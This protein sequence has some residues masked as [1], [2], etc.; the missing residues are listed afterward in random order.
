METPKDNE[1]YLRVSKQDNR[2]LIHDEKA[3]LAVAV[4]AVEAILLVDNRKDNG[5]SDIVIAC[6]SGEKYLL[7]TYKVGQELNSAWDELVEEIEFGD[8]G[9]G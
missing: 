7:G 8:N 1:T 3:E 2:R 6:T 4:Q 9:M 5:T